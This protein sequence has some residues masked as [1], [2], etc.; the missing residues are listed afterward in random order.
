MSMF[1]TCLL[2]SPNVF[3]RHLLSSDHELHVP[4]WFSL[5]S[6]SFCHSLNVLDVSALSS[7]C[8]P[9]SAEF[10]PSSPWICWVLQIVSMCLLGSVRVL[11]VYA[12]FSSRHSSTRP[13]RLTFMT[14][15]HVF[16]S[17][18]LQNYNAARSR[19][20]PPVSECFPPC[21]R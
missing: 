7:P 17:A 13:L 12:E 1:C 5:G 4:A 14:C 6:P 21:P 20:S 3:P 11:Q 15:F 9:V 18:V 19:C 16:H 10:F 8:S 2:G